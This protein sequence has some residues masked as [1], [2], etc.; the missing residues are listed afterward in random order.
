MSSS[1][2]NFQQ[3][4]IVYVFTSGTR[5]HFV[6]IVMRKL[7]DPLMYEVLWYKCAVKQW[8]GVIPMDPLTITYIGELPEGVEWDVQI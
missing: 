5:K 3:G 4:D 1:R 2:R 7:V 6:G 8:V